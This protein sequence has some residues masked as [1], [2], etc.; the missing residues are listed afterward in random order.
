[1]RAEGQL[2]FNSVT[3]MLC[4]ALDGLGIAFVTH[5]Q[6]RPHLEDGSL[7]ELLADWSPPFPGYHL[8]YPSGR[9]SAAAFKVVVE[10]LR[11]RPAG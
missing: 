7:I 10:A 3:P 8:Y 5:D 9:Q 4:A 11:Y 2:I 6:V 1:M